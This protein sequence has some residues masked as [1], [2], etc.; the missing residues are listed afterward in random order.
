MVSWVT[1]YR[2]GRAA[3]CVCS[4]P[5]AAVEVNGKPFGFAAVTVD[6]AREGLAAVGLPSFIVD[7]VLSIQNMWAQGGYD[8]RRPATR[9]SRP[10]LTRGCAPP[11]G[12]VA[13]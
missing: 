8:G 1:L 12:P 13:A 4:T 9:R 3:D 2:W 6:Q 10:E 11:R 7:S 5:W